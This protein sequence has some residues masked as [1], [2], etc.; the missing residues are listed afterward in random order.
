MALLQPLSWSFSFVSERRCKGPI[1]ALMN[2][3]GTELAAAPQIVP[4]GL[5][6]GLQRS[7][8]ESRPSPLSPC[9][10]CGQYF[11]TRFSK[12]MGLTPSASA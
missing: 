9:P 2:G 4:N 3:R 7:I 6:P 1:A 12:T 11:R 8:K 5:E 10:G